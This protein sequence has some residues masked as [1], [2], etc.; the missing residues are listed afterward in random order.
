MAVYL[1]DLSA[2]SPTAADLPAVKELFAICARVEGEQEGHE[3]DGDLSASW[4]R[5]DF[6]LSSDAWLI[7]TRQ[8]QVVGYGAVWAVAVAGAE[9]AQGSNWAF[10]VRVHPAYR[11]R[12]IGTLLLRL[13]EQRARAALEN[14]VVRER[15]C[16]LLTTTVAYS[17]RSA[18]A[19]LEREGYQLERSFWYIVIEGQTQ[20]AWSERGRLTLELE[21][22]E[23]ERSAPGS[24][25]PARLLAPA[26]RTMVRHY[27]C[28]EKQLLP[29]ALSLQQA[30]Q[31]KA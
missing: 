16:A 21:L 31:H 14:V 25:G 3:E 12:G 13:A 23:E 28:Y 29:G 11:G 22:E 2:R 26:G 9:L 4:Q 6:L 19:L 10:C 20:T 18:R 5:M 1:R 24:R 8:G 15:G 30:E 7:L 17:N 27:C